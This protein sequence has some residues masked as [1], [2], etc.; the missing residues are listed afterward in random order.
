MTVDTSR[1]KLIEAAYEEIHRSGFQSASLNAILERT[2]VTKGAL[3]HHFKNKQSL[4]YAVVDELIQ[5]KMEQMWINPLQESSTPPL[6]RLQQTILSAGEALSEEEINL[7]CPLNNLSQEMSPIDEGFRTRIDRIYQRWEKCIV[8]VLQEGIEDGSVDKELN[9][10]NTALF[11]IATLEGCM[12]MAK[13]AQ[14]H[15]V[16]MN[17]GQG[18]LDYLQCL[19][20][21]TRGE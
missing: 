8:E 16:L 19:K 3:Y 10:H 18:L 7:G 9:P 17:C 12:G 1:L 20:R 4:G 11:I 15:S 2:G 5:G 13:S 6:E 14:K 21:P